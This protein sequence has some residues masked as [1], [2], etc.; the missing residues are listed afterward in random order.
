MRE[1]ERGIRGGKNTRRG[2]F[3]FLGREHHF[4]RRGLYCCLG[5]EQLA[6]GQYWFVL[7]ELIGVWQTEIRGTYCWEFWARGPGILMESQS[8]GA[9]EALFLVGWVVRQFWAVHQAEL[10]N[11]SSISYRYAFSLLCCVMWFI[12]MLLINFNYVE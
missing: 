9:I 4:E 1:G 8:Q 6:R 12:M 5:L 2:T 7:E 11:N 3:G 10:E